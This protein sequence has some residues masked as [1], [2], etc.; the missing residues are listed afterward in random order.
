MGPYFDRQITAEKEKEQKALEEK[1]EIRPA[2]E[3]ET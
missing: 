3:K 2:Q 1:D